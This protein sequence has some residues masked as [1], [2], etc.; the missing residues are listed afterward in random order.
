MRIIK[1]VRGAL[2]LATAATALFALAGGASAAAWPD[3]PIHVIV[4]FP[5][6]SAA[7]TVARLIGSKLSEKLG[8]PLIVDNRDGASGAIGTAK[9]ASSE[10]DGYTIGITTTTTVVTVPLLDKNVGYKVPD[11]FTPIAMIG[12]SPFVMV[13]HPS[14]PAKTIAD[15]VALAKAKP[16]T[17]SYSSEGEASLARLGAELFAT[18]AGIK[19]NQ[20]PYKSSTQAVIDLLAGRIDSQFGI[21]TTTKRYLQ[22]G[23][24]RALGVTTQRRI[25]ELPDVPT[26][27]ESGLPGYEVTLWIAVIAPAKLPQN[28]VDTLS[29]DIN[30]ALAQ[31][32]IR[33]ALS[34]QAIFA[35]PQTPAE[36][37]ATIKKDLD[38]WG[39]L[40]GKTDLAQ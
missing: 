23:Q 13:V 27:A 9:L 35:N 15:Y 2:V 38:K 30:Q 22:N 7:D 1:A 40:A 28:I 8:Q 5:A 20:I 19:L 24:L 4:P 29:T 6:G 25:P 12:Y 21:L 14:V 39:A 31:D 34:N 33:Q 16:D 11:D 36:L 18:M 10:P 17:L 3:R 37:N 32:D 26:I